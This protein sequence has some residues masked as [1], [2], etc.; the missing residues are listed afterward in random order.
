MI[1]LPAVVV[2]NEVWTDDIARGQQTIPLDNCP[3]TNWC[4]GIQ[5]PQ[6]HTTYYEYVQ[7]PD[8]PLHDYKLFHR[9]TMLVSMFIVCAVFL[10]VF[11]LTDIS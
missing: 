2:V 1:H 9:P 7:W 8:P 11:V 3:D 10:Y 5:A 4:S 6:K